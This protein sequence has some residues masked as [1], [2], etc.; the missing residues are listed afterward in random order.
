MKKYLIIP[1]LIL[2]TSCSVFRGHKDNERAEVTPQ[3]E[4]ALGSALEAIRLGRDAEGRGKLLRIRKKY[5]GTTWAAEA[6]FVLGN[7]ALRAGGRDSVKYLT[8]A[9]SLEAI[10]PYVLLRLARAYRG[11]GD[12]KM[13]E[14]TYRAAGK[15]YPGF[16][17]R[18][19]AVYERA[20]VL[21]E[22]GRR[23]EARALFTAFIKDFP[24][25]SH[26]AEALLRSA[27]L[28][29]GREEY[30]LAG[31]AIKTLI[32]RY[33]GKG[34][35]LEAEKLLKRH[36][37]LQGLSLSD[38][39]ACERGE[40][41]FNAGLYAEAVDEL[42]GLIKRDN[43]CERKAE[44]LLVE[45][46]F[47]LKRYD[48]AETILERRLR[49]G[50]R[51]HERGYAYR[52]AI[53]LLATVY[54]R[55]N[56]P[57]LH[58][59]TIHDITRNFPGSYEAR[60]ALLMEGAFYEDSGRLKEALNTYGILLKGRRGIEAKEGKEKKLSREAR[61]AAWKRGW[62][63]YR[64]GRY[65]EA[66]RD[67]DISTEKLGWKDRRKFAY[68]R[69]RALERAGLQEKARQEYRLACESAMPGYYCYMAA[70][71][72]TDNADIIKA[73]AL[74]EDED[75]G[76]RETKGN[77]TVPGRVKAFKAAFTLI[78]TGLTSEAA[79][80]AKKELSEGAPDRELVS[81]LMEAFYRAGDYY[82]AIWIY[83]SYFYLLYRGEKKI[84]PRLMS[85]AFPIKVVDYMSAKGLT[86][87][88]DPLLVAAVMREESS[89][90]PNTISR[91]GALGLM[92]VM[93]STARFI[94][95][96]SK[97]GPL[98]AEDILEM[99]TNIRLGAWY[100]AY[101]WRRTDGDPVETIAGYNA[102][103]NVVKEWRKRYPL[104]D[105]EFIESIPYTETRNYTK[106]VLKSYEAFRAIA[107]KRDSV[108]AY[109]PQRKGAP[110]R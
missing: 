9:L 75:T 43:L 58:I 56:K 1:L 45:T 14:Q 23:G 92:Q 25:N 74:A 50:R 88:A 34:P 53:S 83:D 76:K 52:N 6:S 7:Q 42:Q 10:R 12:L 38:S 94:A 73:A 67:L 98:S 93:P 95:E 32:T 90:N 27:K 72:L 55:E 54:L 84:S 22:M 39:E 91:T 110:E 37:E 47:R 102:G 89:F 61:S 5:S 35:A 77:S 109:S 3:P 81:G 99:D 31:V 103:L 69:G 60:R 104:E 87:E 86:G 57:K 2:L 26:R 66:Y 4:A 36:K 24:E 11:D 63:L 78:S 15:D 80:E 97:M 41:L 100:I 33:P 8:E 18:G 85:V 106:K 70:K 19:D 28:D 17:Y 59:K 20:L 21:V 44:P 51:D 62:L 107:T 49:R 40:A 64:L 68:W 82:H 16:A 108:L 105:D 65:L 71:R 29:V 96:S 46:L 79:V 30:D 48:A 13:A 101:L